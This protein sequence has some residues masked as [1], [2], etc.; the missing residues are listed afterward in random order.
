MGDLR[1][2]VRLVN[3]G[4]WRELVA[5]FDGLSYSVASSGR[6]HW[7]YRGHAKADWWLKPSIELF[8]E[9]L[10]ASLSRYSIRQLGHQFLYDFQSSASQ[11][12]ANLPPEQ[13]TLE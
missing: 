9:S 1:D 7:I 10:T 2:K 8:Q 5:Q 4:C 6:N 12:L 11:F 3:C 13:D